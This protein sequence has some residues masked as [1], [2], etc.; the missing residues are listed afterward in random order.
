MKLIVKILSI[1][2]TLVV[3]FILIMMAIRLL[4]NPL[5]LTVEYNL[6]NFP[7]DPYGFTTAERLKWGEL[8]MDYLINSEPDDYL[9]TLKFEDGTPLYN[10]REL[11]HMLDVRVLV[12]SALTA[13]YILLG[14]TLLLG[15]TAWKFG[16]LKELW[17]SITLGGWL[18]LG[19]IFLV[20]LST[21][22]DFSAL[23]TAFH[24]LF[25]QGDTW[26]FYESDTLIRLYPLKFWS[27]AFIYV[28]AMTIIGAL[29]CIL[30]PTK[31]IR[32]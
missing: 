30:V 9:A 4:I 2:V 13:W 31:F 17:K 23:F 21:F 16:Y 20:I 32:K 28:G 29:L 18:T 3:P 22:I 5:F 1:L 12:Q 26:L 25:F 6:P 8:S 10:E 15:L 11:S 24:G 7:S 27:D 19:V 14:V